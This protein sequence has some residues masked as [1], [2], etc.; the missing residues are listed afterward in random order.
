MPNDPHVPG[1]GFGPR[2]PSPPPLPSQQPPYLDQFGRPSNQPHQFHDGPPAAWPQHLP[3]ASVVPPEGIGF[4][5]IALILGVAGLVV[6]FLP[7][8]LWEIRQ[9]VAYV[10]ALPGLVFG[11][12]GCAG[13]RKG[14]AVAITGS[15][16]C[17]L[18]LGIWMVSAAVQL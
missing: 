10:F 16:F 8:D 5:V 11:I 9:Y 17:A 4:A 18:A 2:P 7:I 15:V 6:P 13:P 12:I 14:K 1:P 3:N